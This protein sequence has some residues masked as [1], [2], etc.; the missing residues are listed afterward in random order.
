MKGVFFIVLFS[1]L[2]LK[3]WGQEIPDGYEKYETEDVSF[4]RKKIVFKDPFEGNRFPIDT[5]ATAVRK[6]GNVSDTTLA[7][8]FDFGP[9]IEALIERHKRMDE[10]S[11]N[12]MV[13]G[14][15]IQLYAGLERS[16]SEKIKGHFLSM[17]PEVA[18]YQSYSRPTFKV[19]V[20]DYLTRSE[21][22][23]FCQRLKQQFPGAFVV[24]ELIQLQRKENPYQ[25]PPAVPSER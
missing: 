8:N 16:A 7:L 22:E 14:F 21:A 4:F 9:E 17:H 11:N 24:N 23:I 2:T 13:H 3:V 6:G 18:L 19:R 5:S 12:R 10:G 20:G 15:R 25:L 1:V